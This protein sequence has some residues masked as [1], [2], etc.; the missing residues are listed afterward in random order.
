MDQEIVQWK[1]ALDTARTE[2]NTLISQKDQLF[3]ADYIS[4]LAREKLFFIYPGEKVWLLSSEN[5]EILSSVET[6]GI[7]EE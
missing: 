4:I 6:E 7:I 2:Q 5:Q 3:D 1:A